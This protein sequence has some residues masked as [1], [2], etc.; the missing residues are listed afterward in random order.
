ML[1]DL[2]HAIRSLGKA[3]GF[4]AIAIATLA[5]G[6]GFNTAVFSVVDAVLLRP[7]PYAK[8]EELVRIYDRNLSKGIPRF[9]ASPRNFLDWR[10]QNG[11][12]SAL[13]AFSDDGRR[14]SRDTSRR[15]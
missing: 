5:L 8:P 7:L 3:P 11:T 15:A 9:S 2:R 10:E 1:G 4:T 6:I 14:S 13:A 12:M